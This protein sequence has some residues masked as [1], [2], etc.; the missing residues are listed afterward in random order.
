MET[1]WSGM[2]IAD[3]IHRIETPL[4]DRVNCVYLFVGT[5]SALLFDTAI[6]P[7]VTSHVKPYLARVGVGPTQ[8]RYVV[9]SHCD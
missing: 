1:S 6:G 9:N 8:I 5:R 4:G 2:E 7:T 3:G